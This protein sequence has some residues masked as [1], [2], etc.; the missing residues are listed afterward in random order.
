MTLDRPRGRSGSRPFA[1]ATAPA[2]SWPGTTESSGASSG[3]RG[4]GTGRTV[5]RVGDRVGGGAARDHASRRRRAPGRSPR[6]RRRASR[7]RCATAQTGKSGSSAATGRARG[8]SRSAAR[9]RCGR[10]RAASARSRARSRTRGRGR[11]RT[12]APTEANG[13]AIGD[14]APL[15]R[16]QVLLEQLG[17]PPRAAPRTRRRARPAALRAGRARRAGSRYVFVAATASS[18]PAASGST[19]SAA[20]ASS[21]SGVV[22][23]R[24]RERAGPA[25]PGH[26][27]EHVGRAARLRERDHRRAARSRGSRRSRR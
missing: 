12:S 4:F 3:S 13:T 25:R 22:R 26:V 9:R 19:A 2:K 6:R 14:A 27:L 7:R 8:R 17:R 20:A 16:G 10:S 24:D 15:E 11:S 23:D 21:E 5:L 1:R 18:A